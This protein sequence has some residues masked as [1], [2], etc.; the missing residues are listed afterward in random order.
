L[1]SRLVAH[2]FVRTAASAAS[3]VSRTAVIAASEVDDV[4]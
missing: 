3:L 1:V 2:L 4:V